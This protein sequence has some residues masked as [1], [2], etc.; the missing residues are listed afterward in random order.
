MQDK[1]IY[2][3]KGKVLYITQYFPPIK[4]LRI[5]IQLVYFSFVFRQCG[6]FLQGWQDMQNGKIQRKQRVPKIKSSR[7]PVQGNVQSRNLIVQIRVLIMNIHVL[8]LETTVFYLG[9]PT[10][11]LQQSRVTIMK[12][13]LNIIL[14]QQKPQQMHNMKM[15]QRYAIKYQSTRKYIKLLE[16]NYCIAHNI[17]SE[18]HF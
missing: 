14:H 13:I 15:F 18:I 9:M 6:K 2:N 3:A 11:S 4:H 5:S 16:T 17:V 1:R 8:N 7:G 10:I 12:Q